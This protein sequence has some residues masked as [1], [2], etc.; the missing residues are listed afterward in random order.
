[1][2]VLEIQTIPPGK[3]TI[4]HVHATE[5]SALETLRMILITASMQKSLPD[6]SKVE[7]SKSSKDALSTLFGSDG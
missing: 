1:M 6:I 3:V 7:F 2:V 5:S 4:I